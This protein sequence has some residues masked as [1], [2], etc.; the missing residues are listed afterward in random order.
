MLNSICKEVE[1]ALIMLHVKTIR[2]WMKLDIYYILVVM[3]VKTYSEILEQW[4]SLR[5]S[6]YKK[7]L[8]EVPRYS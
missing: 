1:P 3:G 5:G 7:D 6:H 2:K 4:R 8:Q